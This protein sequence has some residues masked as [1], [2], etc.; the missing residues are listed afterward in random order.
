MFTTLQVEFI[1]PDKWLL[2]NDLKWT[3][4]MG[5]TVII[6]A[7]FDTDFASVPRL[8]QSI[9]RKLG[10]HTLPSV[11]HDWLYWSATERNEKVRKEAD[12]TFLLAMEQEGTPW[13]TRNLMYRAVRDFGAV[14]FYKK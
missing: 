5:R 14:I 12:N 7:G 3:N 1:T 4:G 9:V 10:S 11:L 2:L 6:P 13:F 8:G